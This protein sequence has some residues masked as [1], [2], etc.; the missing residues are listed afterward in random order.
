[1]WLG[2]APGMSGGSPSTTTPFTV[3][4]SSG[5]MLT[6]WVPLGRSEPLAAFAAASCIARD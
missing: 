5:H 4:F 3:R 6:L 2:W 1:M